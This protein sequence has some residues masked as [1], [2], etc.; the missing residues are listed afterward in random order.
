LQKGEDFGKV[1]VAYSI[2]PSAQLNKGDLGFITV[3]SLPY[4]MENVAYSLAPGKISEPFASSSGY[5]IFKNI[6][7]RT[8]GRKNEDRPDTDC[9]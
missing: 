3:F 6:G 2:D 4:Q 8:C 5:H 1:A 7:E 9:L